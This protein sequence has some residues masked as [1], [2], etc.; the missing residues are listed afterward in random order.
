MSARPFHRLLIA[1]RGEIAARIIR[2]ARALGVH[3]IAVFSDADAG[4]P[5]VAMADEAARLG[6]AT[7]SASYLNIPRILEIASERDA[8]AIHPGYGFLSENPDF[9]A[10]VEAAG[11]V[12]VGPSAASISLMGDKAAAKARM[13]KAGVPCVPGYDGEAQD[14]ATLQRAADDLGYP[15][16]IKA[17]AGGGGRGMRA[18]QQSDDFPDALSAARREAAHAFGDDGVLLERLVTHARHVEIQIFAD[19]H[20]DVI[21]LGERDCSTQRRHQKVLEECPSPAVDASLRASMGEAAIAAA[22][23]VDYVGAGTVEFLLDDEGAF[24]FLEMNTR[25]QVEH[26]VTEMVTGLDL[27]RMQLEVAGGAPLP[28][29]DSLTEPCGHAIEARVYL[30]DPYAGFMP[31]AGIIAAFVPP[32]GAGVRCDV[33]IQAGQVASGDYDPMVAKI[34][35]HGPNREVARRRLC[36]ALHETTLLGPTSNRHWLVQVLEH[37]AFVAGDVRTDFLD[38]PS[39]AALFE[40]PLLSSRELAVAAALRVGTRFGAQTGWRNAHPFVQTLRLC[41]DDATHEVVLA[42]GEQPHSLTVRVGDVVHVVELRNERTPRPQLLLDEAPVALSVGWNRD[43]IVFCIG[44]RERRCT[45]WSPSSSA[46]AGDADGTVNAPTTGTVLRVEV[47][48]GDTVAAGQPLLV[49]EA[50]KLETSIVAPVNG[51][52]DEILASPSHQVKKGALLVRI[53]PAPVEPPA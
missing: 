40:P 44:G 34:I 45:P 31:D 8:E 29:R 52:V 20:G 43:E 9:A 4:A 22:Q 51:V 3:T 5:Y 32:T 17:T 38:S 25:L 37:P 41:V 11:L 46:N 7:P 50:M 2:S 12:F 28:V 23:A 33:G 18:V 15:L 6:P 1:N 39:A 26:P 30:E 48:P 21:H 42:L 35:A 10:A 13:Q 49:V 27:V 36:A 47:A 19:S 24:Y 14:D 53:T 16:L